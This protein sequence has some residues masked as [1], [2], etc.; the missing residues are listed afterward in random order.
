[1]DAQAQELNKDFVEKDSI[2]LSV[3]G[4]ILREMSQTIALEQTNDLQLKALLNSNND[5]FKWLG[6]CELENQVISSSDLCI[7]DTLRNHEQCIFIGWLINRHSN[8]EQDTEIFNELVKELHQRLPNKLDLPQLRSTID[9]ML[10]HM[11]QLSW[12]EPWISRKVLTPLFEDD[13]VTF[14]DASQIWH[15]ELINLLEPKTSPSS[16]LFN[17]TREGEVTNIAAWLWTQSSKAHQT[18]CLKNF[19]SV[20]RKQK[21][22]IQQPLASS[23]N[24]SKWDDALKV[25]LWIWLFAE[26]CQYYNSVHGEENSQKLI[27]LYGSA[28]ELTMVRS[29]SEWEPLGTGIQS[30]LFLQRKWVSEQ[31]ENS[32]L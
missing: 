14:G 23:A 27:Q 1:M 7:I 31:I 24:W 12:A 22:I 26:W 11:K 29:E 18:K 13:R 10:G 6:W 5:F 15:E 20:L 25:A 30:E 9:S 17:S 3:L 8:V 28:K 21:Q 4:Q 16:R 2:R 32:E 19:E